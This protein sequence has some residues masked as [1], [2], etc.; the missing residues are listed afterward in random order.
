MI[1]PQSGQGCVQSAQNAASLDYSQP[2][3]PGGTTTAQHITD[4]HLSGISG[5]SQYDTSGGFGAVV[6]TNALTFQF[7]V[8]TPS[9]GSFAFD[10][11]NPLAFFGFRTG[12][13]SFG[14]DAYTNHLVVKSDCKTVITS[15]PQ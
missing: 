7:G 1:K 13:N 5:V 14:K 6:R 4:R 12:T 2:L 9:R 8:Q 15:Y 3:Y 10:L 11:I